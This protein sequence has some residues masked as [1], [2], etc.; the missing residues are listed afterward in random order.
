MAK[1]IRVWDGSDWQDVSPA[2]PYTISVRWSK[3]YSAGT[4]AISGTDDY[5]VSLSYTP[6]Y[7]QVYLNGVLLSRGNDYTATNGTSI[8]LSSATATND[9]VEV[10][11][12]EQISYADT[13]TQAQSNSVFVQNSNNFVAGKNKIING[14]FGIWQRGTS[15]TAAGYTADRWHF[16][17]SGTS[18]SSI[19]RQDLPIG[20]I[21][22]GNES[23]NFA[24]YTR[25]ATVGDD[26]FLQRVEDVRTLLGKTVTF[27]FWAKSS[28][29]TTISQ[30]YGATVYGSGG[31]SG[32]GFGNFSGIAIGT[33]WARYSY[34]ATVES[35]TG[36][37]VGTNSFTEL[38]FK[39]GSEMGNI[40]VDIWGVQLEQGSN[41][42]AFNTSTGTIQGELAVCHRY[43]VKKSPGTPGD[44]Y[45]GSA[46]VV[47]DTIHALTAIPLPVKMRSLPTVSM[48]GIS[49]LTGAGANIGTSLANYSSEVPGSIGLYLLLA[50]GATQGAAGYLYGGGGSYMEINAEL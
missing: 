22:G 9:I 50:S 32:S 2:L 30:V 4:T 49:M 5:S 15:F 41:L 34:T 21:S 27:S 6:G 3:Q 39:F 44:V 20:S 29:A 42:T 45:Y 35:G 19:T 25:T 24:R 43:Y 12:A 7:E 8:T 13:Y 36:K 40:T 17:W 37:T 26:Y 33:T 11:C 1:R 18:T 16:S 48:S 28:A 14:D 23:S 10:I 47:N 46:M 38:V 31:S